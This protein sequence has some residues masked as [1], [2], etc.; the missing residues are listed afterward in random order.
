MAGT[1]PDEGLAKYLLHFPDNKTCHEPFVEWVKTDYVTETIVA[2]VIVRYGQIDPITG[3][4]Y[5]GGAYR[6]QNK[7]RG[8]FIEECVSLDG[9]TGNAFKRKIQNHCC[10]FGLFTNNYLYHQ[11]K[12]MWIT[13]STYKGSFEPSND[14]NDNSE[15]TGFGFWKSADQKTEKIG[16]FYQ[17]QLNGVYYMSAEGECD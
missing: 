12:M 11:G 15:Q 9:T 7:V 5:P 13:G 1:F 16:F 10:S 3:N 2:P 6:E 8:S 14:Y 4:P 17:G